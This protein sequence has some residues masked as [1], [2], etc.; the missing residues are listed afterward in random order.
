MPVSRRTVIGSVLGAPSGTGDLLGFGAQAALQSYSRSQEMQADKLGARYMSRAGYDPHA[1]TDFFAKLDAQT[2]IMAAK[3]GRSGD[4]FSIMSTHPR[5][6]D[7]I[8]QARDLAAQMTP[9]QAVRNRQSMLTQVDGMLF[10]PDPKEGFMRGDTFIHPDLGFKFDFPPDFQVANGKSAVQGTNGQGTAIIFDMESANVSSGM[11][12]L[13]AYVRDHWAREAGVQVSNLERLD[14]NGLDAATGTTRANTNQGQRDVRLLAIRASR[15]RIY[16]FVFLTPPDAT[17]AMSEQLRRTTY[18]F[19]LLKPGE[20]DNINPPHIRVRNVQSGD[21]IQS[22]ASAMPL[23]KYNE[24]WFRTL[25]LNVVGDGLA[26]GE[27]VKVVA[28]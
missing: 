22:F 14:I 10:G 18:S 13:A 5:T 24:D 3:A 15:E 19:R 26:A 17:Q 16:R 9:P 1:L 6:S 2:Q 28:E 12:D 25:N 27:K 21:S 7:R 23:G 8:A 4:N 11:S 20:A